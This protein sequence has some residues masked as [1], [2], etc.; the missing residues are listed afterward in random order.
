MVTAPDPCDL[1]SL[2]DEFV[3][4]NRTAAVVLS[5]D[6]IE[7][8]A[9]TTRRSFWQPCHSWPP[10]MLVTAIATSWSRPDSGG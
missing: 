6:L 10:F 8:L 7:N 3:R 1:A 4:I 9:V 2:V 5:R